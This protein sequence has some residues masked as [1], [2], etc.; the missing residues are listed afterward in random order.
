MSDECVFRCRICHQVISKPFISLDRRT[1][2]YGQRS[3]KGKPQTAVT[4]L[5]SLELFRYDSQDCWHFHGPQVVAELQLKTNYPPARPWRPA[6]VAARRWTA[7]C[8]TS[9]IPSLKWI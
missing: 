2:R 9:V 4:M 8:P 1:Q 5:E 6:A 7:P 3:W